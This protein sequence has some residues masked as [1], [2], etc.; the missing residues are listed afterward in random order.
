MK[1]HIF[2]AATNETIAIVNSKDEAIEW[3]NKNCYTAFNAPFHRTTNE[4]ITWETVTWEDVEDLRETRNRLQSKKNAAKAQG[5]MKRYERYNKRYNEVVAE[6][7]VKTNV[8]N[9]VA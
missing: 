4:R 7:T 3:F 5:N 8:L 9:H 2:S 1:Y 6:I